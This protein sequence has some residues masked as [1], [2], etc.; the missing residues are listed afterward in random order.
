MDVG[1]KRMSNDLADLAKMAELAGCQHGMEN[2][3][4]S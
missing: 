2:G 4:L 1:V 3:S